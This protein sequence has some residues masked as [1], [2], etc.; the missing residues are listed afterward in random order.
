MSIESAVSYALDEQPPAALT[1]DDRG[2][3]TPREYEIAGLVAQGLTNR[4][5]AEQLVIAKRTAETHIDHILNKLDLANRV[6]IAIW[7]TNRWPAG[8]PQSVLPGPVPKTLATVAIPTQP[9]STTA[10][11]GV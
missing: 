1:A 7:I 5:I 6:Q 10:W 3:L 8:G 2:G 9:T 11:R 4:E